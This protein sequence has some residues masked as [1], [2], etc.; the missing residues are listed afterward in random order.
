[1]LSIN[2][3]PL[4]LATS[5]TPTVQKR[6]AQNTIS[7]IVPNPRSI[8]VPQSYQEYHYVFCENHKTYNGHT[9]WVRAY[10]I[11]VY[12]T[13]TKTAVEAQW[14]PSIWGGYCYHRT[15]Y[16]YFNGH[17]NDSLDTTSGCSWPGTTQTF[18]HVLNGGEYLV[19]RASGD[20]QNPSAYVSV[21]TSCTVPPRY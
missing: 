5:I 11:Y 18:Y 10:H 14:V 19:M 16:A 8:I 12:G 20:F 2:T 4:V 13:Y 17:L 1:M 21:Y 9:V 6:N 7:I 3:A 15:F